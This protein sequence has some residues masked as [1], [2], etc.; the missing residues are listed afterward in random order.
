MKYFRVKYGYNNDEFISVDE[1]EMPMAMRAHIS[2]KKGVFKEG[3]ISGD[4]IIV[5]VPDWQ[6]VMGW[7]R[8][9]N[10]MSEDYDEIG[11]KTQ[12]EYQNLLQ[13]TRF[14]IEN[15]SQNITLGLLSSS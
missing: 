4:K 2:G 7:N 13:E 11:S 1:K 5:I 6:R 15:G 8:T 14:Q 12:R 3:S 9:Y 10:L